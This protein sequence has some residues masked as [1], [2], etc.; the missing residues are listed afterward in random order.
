METEIKEEG[1]TP[2]EK[3][4]AAWDTME[5]LEYTQGKLEELA[6]VLQVITEEVDDE[7][8]RRPEIISSLLSVFSA[9]FAEQNKSIKK[10]FNELIERLYK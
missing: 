5:R 3:I 8:C 2:A 4:S 7:K 10:C 9:S 6:N 1:Q